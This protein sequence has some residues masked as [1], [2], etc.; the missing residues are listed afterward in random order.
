MPIASAVRS[1]D[2][3]ST[4][5]LTHYMV[6]TLHIKDQQFH[7]IPFLIL[8]LRKH[9]IILGEKWVSQANALLDCRNKKIIWRQDISKKSF[10]QT[11]KKKAI[12]DNWRKPQ[13][14]LSW[15]KT[16][17]TPEEIITLAEIPSAEPQQRW[18]PPS[19]EDCPEDDDVIEIPTTDE[20]A[21]SDI[22]DDSEIT[23]D[24]KDDFKLPLLSIFKKRPN[25]RGSGI[26]KKIRFDLPQQLPF[27]DNDTIDIC[28]I[29]A[30]PFAMAARQ[31][32]QN[33]QEVW[34]TSL[35]EIN[36]MLAHLEK[37]RQ[38]PQISE[39]MGSE[40]PLT[41]QANESEEEWL[42]RRLPVVLQDK[43]RHFSKIAANQFPPSRKGVDF[44]IELTE[45]NNLG[46][47]PLFRQTEAQLKEIK[48]YIEE[49]TDKG[50]IEASS[51][52]FAA[53]VLFVPKPNGT[54]RFCVDYRKLNAITKKDRY[55]PPLIDETL[56][57]LA[58]CTIFT[59]LD[60]RQ[61]FHRIQID[62]GSRDLTTFR[63][64][65]GTYRYNVI[66]F[67]LS[68]GPAV[69]QR[70]INN[71]L[72]DFLDKDV[73]AYADDILIYGKDRKSH[74]KRVREVLDRLGEMGLQADIDKSEF[75]IDCTKYLG[76]IISKDGISID[77]DKV[78]AV[79][80]WEY[81][82]T[83][84]GLQA[85][86][87][88]CNFYRKFIR[89]YGRIARPLTAM[90]RKGLKFDF[91]S[92]C[93][94][95]FDGL[96]IALTTGPTLAY[97]QWD[98]PHRVETDSSNG[99]VAGLITQLS[100]D[101]EWHPVAYF[102]KTMNAA[103]C[104]YP[105]HDKELL[106]IIRAF[107]EWK[108]EL[109]GSQHKVDVYTDH[110]AL[111][112]FMSTKELTA[113]QVRWA[114][115]LTQFNFNIIYRAG[116]DNGRADA[117]TRRDEDVKT[118]KEVMR[119]ARKLTVLTKEMLSDEVTNDLQIA[120]I[121]AELTLT[122]RALEANRTADS[123][124]DYR[125]KALTENDVWTM[126]RGLVLRNGQLVVPSDDEH[127]ILR[128]DIIREAH[129]QRSMAHPAR[130]KMLRA[131]QARYYWKGMGTDVDRYIRNCWGCKRAKPFK[132]KTPGLLQ[133]L[134]IPERP[135]QHVTMDFTEAPTTKSGYDM[136]FVIVDRLGKR[137]IS[138]PCHKN[139][140]ARE[141][142]R[143]FIQWPY[144]IYGPP[145]SIVS[146]RGPQFISEF[147]DEFCTALDIKLKLSTADHPQ[148][149]GQTEIYNQYL[150]MRLRHFLNFY[151][152]NWDEL[153]PI[154]D[155]AQATLVSETTGLSPMQTELGFDPRTTFDWH[156]D[157]AEYKPN[158]RF[159]RQDA[160]DRIRQ[161]EEAWNV[162]REGMKKAQERQT[163]QANKSRKE[164][165]FDVGDKVFI[166]RK[167]WRTLQPS[168]KLANQ[169][170]GPFEVLERK[171]N[172]FILNFPESI[173]VHN[174]VNANKLRKAADD[175]LPGQV[176]E[177]PE[178]FEV[179]GELEWEVDQI[180][181]V[182][183][184][185][186]KLKYRVRW[187]GFDED[188]KE[189]WAGDLK[190]AP[191]ALKEFHDEYPQQPGP[192]QHLQYWLEC[193]AK[194]EDPDDRAG[195]DLPVARGRAPRRGR[196]VV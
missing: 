90:T 91:N 4:Q 109:I 68:N 37:I 190:N 195:D 59:K 107:E 160:Q 182:R 23:S 43:W 102:S 188:L 13:K 157:L 126:H 62:E 71:N 3:Y 17:T 156:R 15:K 158:D 87:G 142:A 192:P 131:L 10:D 139:I 118:Q 125:A 25:H 89:D 33:G 73:S 2:G 52:P 159:N 185:Y 86:L 67:G 128:T 35:Y 145:D 194:D 82:T 45:A 60:I 66:P 111:E 97:F 130:F 11:N 175:P 151:Q 127:A 56:Q 117:L 57:R 186:G 40:D 104:N 6:L 101:Q 88:F 173:K 74:I 72:W 34:S 140:T 78:Q 172:A 189:Y 79:A 81:P 83:L 65:Y 5:N 154:M 14:V 115:F 147:W 80:S 168:R 20:E 42:T 58:G 116:K 64:R 55:P 162:A 191:I 120:P 166:C 61:A 110:R 24:D 63:T 144:R 138:I 27:S 69:F 196:G 177:E 137:A 164:I 187:K 129:T 46:Y 75:M 51:A 119:D 85:F 180:L 132:D 54:L 50:F 32:K 41:R 77:P 70:F 134:A 176:N 36:Q 179:N 22:K 150:K 148:T 135:W 92:N 18:R 106:A 133:P 122:D 96:K 47:S 153:L 31:A 103:E 100:D 8:N 39:I 108:P 165:D 143:L 113:R 146:D 163:I 44:K 98:L 53:P 155:L 149:D 38:E 26:S 169:N 167:Y 171:G 174:P 178:P 93:K 181:G 183:E 1:F 84:K 95:A 49:Y 105:I 184:V 123:L 16:S 121:E 112:W 136:I 193:A 161:L 9:D 29:G 114:E 7:K 21:T 94:A 170:A 141:A 152:D 28:M 76:F 30:A 124:A 19:C 99:V 48:K 12:K